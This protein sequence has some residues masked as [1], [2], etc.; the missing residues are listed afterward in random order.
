MAA[1]PNDFTQPDVPQNMREFYILYHADSKRLNTKLDELDKSH[2]EDRESF[3][4]LV[5][6]HKKAIAEIVTC[7]KVQDERILQLDKKVSSWSL[8]NTVIA[9]GAA[10][11][12]FFGISK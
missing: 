11:A 10:V 3:L 4:E 7:A 8:T 12:G 2:E 6:G 5:E 9:I 1:T